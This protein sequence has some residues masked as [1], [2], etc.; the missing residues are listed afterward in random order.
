M[1]KSLS[2]QIEIEIT[3]AFYLSLLINR[4]SEKCV[5]FNMS[6]HVSSIEIQVNMSKKAYMDMPMRSEIEY[7]ISKQYE[8]DV[9][10]EERLE[11]I[12]GRVK[13]LETVCK[14]NKI[15]YKNM[16]KIMGIIGYEF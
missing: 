8:C 1:E 9:D 3:K 2:E 15:S 14:E 10:S 5:F 13:F 7:D 11:W 6:G 4:H 12:K 16:N